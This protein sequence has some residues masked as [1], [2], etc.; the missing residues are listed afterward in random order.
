MNGRLKR[1]GTRTLFVVG[2]MLFTI[3]L[4]MAQE[5]RNQLPKQQH[6]TSNAPFLKPIRS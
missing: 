4:V 2:L 5:S 1:A 6:K 3:P